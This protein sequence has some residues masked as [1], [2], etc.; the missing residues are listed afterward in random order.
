VAPKLAVET[1]IYASHHQ[2]Y[3]VDPAARDFAGEVWDG[4]GLERHVGVAAGLVAVGTVGYCDVPVRI[5]LW[6]SE[7][8]SDLEDWDHVVEATLELGSG[9]LGLEGV[10]GPG[11]LEPLEVAPGSYRVR[12]SAGD[13]D[14]ADEMDGG[15]RYRVQLWP[16]P[17]R[18]PEVLRWWAQWDPRGR[19]PRPT[20]TGGEVVL[21]AEAEDRRR[22]M[23]WLGSR[24][25]AHLFEDA[26]GR[27]WEHSNLPDARGTPQ[28][29]ELDRPEAERRYGSPDEWG[30]SALE[31][32]S[33]GQMLRNV[34]QTWRYS[35]GRRPP[36]DSGRE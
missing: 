28:L 11:E 29:E 7:P 24:G 35:R 6:E 12:T 30:P 9:R 33:A 15:D 21:G 32:P 5:E 4:A 25:H 18:E 8:P 2:F 23:R 31:R 3:V 10:E 13:L 34:W 22:Q 1:G 20:T 26:A 27:L 16:G 14:D 19:Q 17:F 36:A